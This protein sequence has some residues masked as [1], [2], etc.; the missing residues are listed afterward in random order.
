MAALGAVLVIERLSLIEL[1]S[2]KLFYQ[3][4]AFSGRKSMVS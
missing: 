1:K 2:V 3:I 4:V